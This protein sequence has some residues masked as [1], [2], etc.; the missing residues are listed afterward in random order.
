MAIGRIKIV[1]VACSVLYDQ[2]PSIA[3]VGV[4]MRHYSSVRNGIDAF[5]TC[6]IAL[7]YSIGITAVYVEAQVSL[8]VFI[9]IVSPAIC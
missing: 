4:R 2:A 9:K 1:P 3:C 8:T 6:G 5:S 7:R